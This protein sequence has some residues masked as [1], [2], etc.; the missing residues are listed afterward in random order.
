[1]TLPYDVEDFTTY[2]TQAQ[3]VIDHFGNANRLAL[4]LQ[5]LGPQYA[6]HRA[7]VLR[8]TWPKAKQGTG[9]VIPS[10]R[11]P[12]IKLVCRQH[13]VLLTEKELQP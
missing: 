8:W 10:H 11:M 13:G 2:S 7:T 3:R 1:M 5:A 12:A 4:A 6:V 9:G